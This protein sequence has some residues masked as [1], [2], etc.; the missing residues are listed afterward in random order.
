[1]VMW[2]TCCRDLRSRGRGFTLIELMFV[3]V[4][5]AILVTIAAPSMRDMLIATQVRGAASDLYESVILARSEAIKRSAS[6]D[7]VPTGG[8]WTTGW[9]VMVGATVVETREAA[10][11]VTITPNTTGNVTY[12]LDGRVSSAVRSLTVSTTASTSPIAA[13]CVVLDAGGRASIKTDT[14]NNAANGC[15]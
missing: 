13:R 3:I 15:N 10:P 1:M 8:D 5:L 14:D 12:K 9:K 4:V 11:N 2:M 7:V 6:V